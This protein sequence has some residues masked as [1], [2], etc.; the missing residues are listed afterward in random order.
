MVKGERYIWLLAVSCWLLAVAGCQNVP[1]VEVR[2]RE[3]AGLPT[4]GRAAACACTLNGKG[5]V[6]A[7][8]DEKGNYQND[9]WLYDPTTDC[10]TDL[11]KAPMNPRVNATITAY[12]DKLYAGL[13]YSAHGA[14]IDTAYQRDW[15][16]YTPA[17]GK[18]KRLADYPNANTVAPLSF[19]IGDYLYAIY[20]FGYGFTRDVCRYDVASDRWMEMPDQDERPNHNFGGRGAWLNGMYYYGTGYATYSMNHWYVA[21]VASDHWERR[22]YVPGKGRQFCAC[23]ASSQYVYLFGGRHFAGDLTG[24][25]VFET[26]LRYSPDQDRWEWCGTMPCGRAE[27]QIAFTIDSKAYVG[28]GENENGQMI[29][30]LYR[31]ED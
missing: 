14:Y 20:G 7:G 4:G 16:E 19:A 26:Y 24:G 22:T 3:C 29:K 10:W 11:G 8:R 27:N 23:A 9:L 18:W 31:I 25:E 1:E 17:S 5:Y 13:G 12:G 21:D 30:H 6:F 28:L 2:V 15:W